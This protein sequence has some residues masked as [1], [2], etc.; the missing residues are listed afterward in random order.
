M[1]DIYF[2]KI[3]LLGT[4][5]HIYGHRNDTFSEPKLT[6]STLLVG[7]EEPFLKLCF[8][9]LILNMSFIMRFVIVCNVF[10][11]NLLLRITNLCDEYP[12][13]CHVK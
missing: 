10:C 13:N 1:T 2:T 7:N 5:Y 6:E 11:I 3:L 12:L 8:A 4:K 9:F